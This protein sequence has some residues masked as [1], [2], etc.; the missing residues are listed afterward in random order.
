VD[1]LIDN[2]LDAIAITD[3][4]STITLIANSLGA[5][6]LIN[7]LEERVQGL[8]VKPANSYLD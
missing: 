4:T 7:N 8:D 1:A 2:V 3:N 5:F 6:G